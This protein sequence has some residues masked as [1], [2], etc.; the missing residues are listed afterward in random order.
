MDIMRK[1]LILMICIVLSNKLY[2]NGGPILN[3]QIIKTGQIQLINESNISISNEIINVKVDGEYAIYDI[4]YTFTK[5]NNYWGD[6]VLYGFSVDFIDNIFGNI[7]GFNNKDVQFFD[8][9]FNN[10]KLDLKEQIDFSYYKDT[11]SVKN[12]STIEY[13]LNQGM[14]YYFKHRKKWFIAKLFF[15]E[16]YTHQLNVKY[17][18][19]NYSSDLWIAKYPFMKYGTR[20]LIYDLTPAGYWGNGIIENLSVNIDVKGL[21]SNYESYQLKG[22]DGYSYNNGKFSYQSKNF[23]PLKNKIFVL[24]YTNDVIGKTTDIRRNYIEK[25]EIKSIKPS[26]YG[27]IDNLNDLNPST[28]CSFKKILKKDYIDFSFSGQTGFMCMTILNGNYL[29]EDEYYNNARLK[30]IKIEYEY[31]GWDTTK[32]IKKDTI[33][34]LENRK[35]CPVNIFNFAESADIIDLNVDPFARFEK[36]KVTFLEYYQGKKNNDV[37][38]SEILLNGFRRWQE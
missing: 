31:V 35:Y 36:F 29:N 17:K 5:E 3:S 27:N 9:Y 16:E 12:D 7:K 34:E 22:L 20:K 6:T 19:K 33:I 38:I 37:C 23:D 25:K 30:K 4:T 13:P 14:S 18:V 21:D 15:G 11:I 24:E 32:I 10:E 1:L 2:S 26:F 28:S 8:M